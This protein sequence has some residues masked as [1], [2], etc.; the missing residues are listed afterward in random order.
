MKVDKS[1]WKKCAVLHASLKPVFYIIS[2]QRYDF[3]FWMW[4][5]FEDK[6]CKKESH[7]T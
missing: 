6:K 1:A 5:R 7:E 2:I 3:K 4:K